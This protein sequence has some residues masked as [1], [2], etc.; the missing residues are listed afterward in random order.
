VKQSIRYSGWSRFFL[1]WLTSVCPVVGC[2]ETGGKVAAHGASE[3]GTGA[4]SDITDGDSSG[5]PGVGGAGATHSAGRSQSIGSGTED[6]SAIRETGASL[7][8]LPER[9]T[10]FAFS[11]PTTCESLASVVL[12]KNGDDE[13]VRIKGLSVSTSDFALAAQLPVQ[14]EV[15]ATLPVGVHYIGA[16]EDGVEGTLTAST[17]IGCF[18]FPV[19]G[20]AGGERVM[21]Y[22]DRAVDFGEVEAGAV[23]EPHQVDIL[24]QFA[25]NL[26]P[27]TLQ[28]FSASPEDIFEIVTVPRITQPE[29]CEVIQVAVRFRAPQTS[30]KFEGALVWRALMEAAEGTV[31]IPLYGTSR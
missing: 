18:D 2:G 17:S 11:G 4:S 31:F 1:I 12:L 21:T 6:C 23:S 24:F 8:M 25:P 15:G 13:S 3:A 22:T 30:G 14:L 26:S 27:P 20:L 5:A 9:L 16:S 19:R 7:Q 10:T 29:S 28:G